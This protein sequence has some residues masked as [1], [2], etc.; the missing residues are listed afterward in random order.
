MQRTWRHRLIGW[1]GATRNDLD[2]PAAA[3]APALGQV[4]AALGALP[5]ARLVRMTGS[6]ATL[7]AL[8]ERRAQA[9][10]GAARLARAEPGW[11]VRAARLS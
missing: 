7:F 2:A 10:A 8:F 5:G 6:G 3:L 11:W 1:L 9:E 4:R